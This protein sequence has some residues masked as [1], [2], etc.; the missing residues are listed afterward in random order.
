MDGEQVLGCHLRIRAL[1]RQL[2]RPLAQGGGED[3]HR[4]RHQVRVGDPGAVEPVAGFQHLV[5]AHLGDGR[6]VDLRVP[7]A[8]DERRHPAQGVRASPMAG[9]DQELRVGPHER[10]GHRDLGAVGEDEVRT[11]GELLDDAKDVVP[12]PRVEAAGVIPQLIEDLVHL[13]GAQDRLHQHRAFD[14]PTAQIERVFREC[15]HVVPKSG[16]QMALQLRKVEVGTGPLG[17]QAAG[18]MKDIEPEVEERA[19]HRLPVDQEVPFR[20]MPSAWAHQQG[21][22]PISQPIRLAVWAGERNRSIDRIDQVHLAADHVAPRRCVRVLEVG[23]IDTGARIEGVDDHLPVGGAG[24]LHLAVGEIARQGR[25]RPLALADVAGLRQ[26]VGHRAGGD[27]G[28]ALSPRL[29]QAFPCLI[30]LAV[31][32]GHESQGLGREHVLKA[33]QHRP[34]HIYAVQR[35]THLTTRAPCW[36]VFSRCY[37]YLIA[38]TFGCRKYRR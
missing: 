14:R 11:V 24:D 25:D 33:L 30:E 6:L 37:R 23:H 26:K 21:G 7:A 32:A 27:F 4:H 9:P 5:L 28:L 17:Q 35:C 34:A 38:V 2:V 36:C 13:E 3:L 22:Q 18:V 10:D 8:G 12:P 29:Q 16:F 1:L 31:Q 20:Q 15:K 19:G